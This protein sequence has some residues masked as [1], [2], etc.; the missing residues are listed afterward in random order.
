VLS[1]VD[2]VADRRRLTG[3]VALV[4][5]AVALGAVAAAGTIPVV[6]WSTVVLVVGLAGALALSTRWRAA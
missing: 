3:A 4:L 2:A 5:V 1:E 6:L